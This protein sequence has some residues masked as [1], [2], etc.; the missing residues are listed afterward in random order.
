VYISH[1]QECDVQVLRTNILFV[2]KKWYK[3]GIVC[4]CCKQMLFIAISTLCREKMDYAHLCIGKK[5]F[6]FLNFLKGRNTELKI[7]GSHR[8][9]WRLCLQ[10]SQQLYCRNITFHAVDALWLEAH[11]KMS[12]SRTSI[13]NTFT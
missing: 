2:A 10:C 4:E 3:R 1:G 12:S 8:V 9:L 6:F 7:P 5:R 13:P 11:N